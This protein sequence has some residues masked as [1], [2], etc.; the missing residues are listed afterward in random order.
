MLTFDLRTGN[1]LELLRAM[2]ANFVQCVVTSPLYYGLRSYSI[3]A[4]VWGGDNSCVHQWEGYHTGRVTGGGACPASGDNK[5]PGAFTADHAG[6]SAFCS[7][8]GAFYGWLG[9][10]PTP[11]MFIEHLV[12]IFHEVRRVL[13]EDGTLWLNLGDSFWGGK[14]Q[15]GMGGKE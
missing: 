1:T 7:V 15:S 4:D 2:P 11:E 5:W 13:R 6:E 14:G 12:E 9:L 10:E 3:P 8:C